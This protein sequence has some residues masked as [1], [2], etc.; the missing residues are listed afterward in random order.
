M[1]PSSQT[2]SVPGSLARI[3]RAAIADRAVAFSE[4]TIS[5]EIGDRT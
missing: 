2:G 3:A 4:L 1:S 5:L